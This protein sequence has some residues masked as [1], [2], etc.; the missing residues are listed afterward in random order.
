MIELIGGAIL[1]LRGSIRQLDAADGRAG[2]RVAL[3]EVKTTS[4]IRAITIREKVSLEHKSCIY[5]TKLLTRMWETQND[6]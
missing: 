5:L 4:K 2:I 6:W 1:V 3:V